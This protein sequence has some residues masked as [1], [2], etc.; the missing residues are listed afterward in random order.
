MM[1]YF[2][3]F[4]NAFGIASALTGASKKC[5]QNCFQFWNCFWSASII[6]ASYAIA[7]R[8]HAGCVWHVRWLAPAWHFVEHEGWAGIKAWYQGLLPSLAS[9]PWY[10][11]LAPGLGIKALYQGL[12]PSFGHLS[13]IIPAQTHG[14]DG[15]HVLAKLVRMEALSWLQRFGWKFKHN[16]RITS[17]GICL[18][19]GSDLNQSPNHLAASS[20]KPNDQLLSTDQ[21]CVSGLVG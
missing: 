7:S 15:R 13:M 10:Q 12:L 9:K 16:F 11:D 8:M 3:T 14:S 2:C 18:L 1:S 5:F 4:R 19:T 21:G 17:A 6:A 20:E